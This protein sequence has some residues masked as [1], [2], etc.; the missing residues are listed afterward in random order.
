MPDDTFPILDVGDGDRAMKIP[1]EVLQLLQFLDRPHSPDY[2]RGALTIFQSRRLI[3]TQDLNPLISQPEQFLYPTPLTPPIPPAAQDAR[4]LCRG[5]LQARV[6]LPTPQLLPFLGLTL[7]YDSAD[8][9]TLH[10]LAERLKVQTYPQQAL[11]P[12]IANLQE[13]LNSERFEAIADDND[14]QYTRAGQI[15]LITMHKAKGL[16]WDYV[17]IPSLHA[18]VIPGEA[19]VPNGAKFLGNFTLSEV[20]RAQIRTALHYDY[21]HHSPLPALPDAPTAWQ[22]AIA[23]KEAEEY[24]LLYVAMTRAKRLLWLSAAHKAPFRWNQV[25]ARRSLS[26]QAKA[27]SPALLV[28]HRA[29]QRNPQKVRL[30]R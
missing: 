8:L 4:R 2:L 28:L 13:L 18:D 21:I 22:Q 19:W 12:L 11:K 15:T 23:L 14:A 25:Q 6:A 1:N 27:P 24:R 20:A 16:D 10:K 5:L 29:R 30:K 3:K 9:A 17:F 26:L 7:Q